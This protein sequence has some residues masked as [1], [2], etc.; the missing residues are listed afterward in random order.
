M[1]VGIMPL[2]EYA[3]QTC[4]KE[5]ET[6]VRGGETPECPVC[7]GTALE[8]QF[9]V[10]APRAAGGESAPEAMSTPGGCGRCGDPRGLGVCSFN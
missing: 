9:S 10:F 8:R 4:E 2:Y 5:F 3:C 6:L 7:H 1:I